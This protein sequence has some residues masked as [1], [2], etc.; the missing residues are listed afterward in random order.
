MDKD[1]ARIFVGMAVC[2]VSGVVMLHQSHWVLAGVSLAISVSPLV[3]VA[4][5]INDVQV[6]YVSADEAMRQRNTKRN[7]WGL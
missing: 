2:A 5:L 3:F 1:V 6:K 4:W 7:F